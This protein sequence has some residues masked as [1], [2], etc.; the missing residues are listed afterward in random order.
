VARQIRIEYEGAFYHVTSRGNQKQPIFFNDLNYLRFLDSLGEAHETYAATFHAYC[1]MK[2]H[3]HFM[4]ETP[5][6]NL[7][8]IMHFL[9][10]SY[11]IYLNK[12]QDRVGHLFQGRFKS[13]LIE[14]DSYVQ[15]L[16]RYIHMNPV[17]AKIAEC[18]DQYVWSSYRDYIGLRKSPPWLKTDFILG[19]FNHNRNEA[20]QHYISYVL[21]TSVHDLES[22]RHEIKRSA[23]LGSPE[24]IE[25]TMRL[26]SPE[27]RE[28]PEL[29]LLRGLRER[30]S[31][32]RIQLESDRVLGRANKY[33]RDS[34][35]FISRHKEGYALRAVA[36]YFSLSQS[37][38][39]KISRRMKKLITGN[40]VLRQAIDEI[41]KNLL[42]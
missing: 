40:S 16:S 42:K 22:L 2:N 34:V 37:G 14:A 24:F 31:L 28:D 32:N 35:I 3:F 39:V 6:A 21:N 33:N 17:I 29:P 9:N 27:F 23:I 13:I 36:D 15:R 20:R 38:V 18:P 10:T 30:P 8:Q 7:S 5:K 1:L 11:S 12:S 19:L 4:I 41:E 25:K 26:I